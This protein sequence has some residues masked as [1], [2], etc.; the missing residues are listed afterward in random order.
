ME[1][2]LKMS[3]KEGE[4]KAVF[5]MVKRGCLTLKQAA[6]QSNLSYRQACRVFKAYLKV[7]DAGL[8][9][10]NRDQQSNRKHPHQENIIKCYKK[11]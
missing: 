6:R 11:Y 4:R 1:D 3:P 2:V 8:I 10:K 7:G 9:H 5:E